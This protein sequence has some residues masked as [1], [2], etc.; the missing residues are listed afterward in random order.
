MVVLALALS[1]LVPVSAGAHGGSLLGSA[2]TG[3]YRTQV[4]AA[5]LLERGRPPAIDITVYV[6]NATSS[7]P[8]TDATVRTTVTAEGRTT[9]PSVR[10]IA[11][12]YEVVVPVKDAY[13]VGQQRID[14]QVA[15]P[16]GTGRITIEPAAEAEEPPVVAI[17][18]SVAIL[19]ALCA[20]ALRV[21][22]RRAADGTGEATW[23]A[24]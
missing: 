4:T 3:P 10:Q 8:V 22:R 17:V 11:A 15:G 20:V 5:P 13:T 7:A 23:S 12:G 14:V 6:S 18:A 19:L 1:G 21:R 2:I 9:R 16:A 24:G